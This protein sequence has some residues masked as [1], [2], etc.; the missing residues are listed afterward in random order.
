ML[1]QVR[2]RVTAHCL[3]RELEVST[4]TIYRDLD[5]LSAAGVPVYAERGPGGGCAL[6]EGYRTTLTGLTRDE[7]QAL[8]MLT[9][10]AP[11]VEL[12]VSQALRAALLKL[13]AAL[14]A[15]GRSEEERVRQRVHLDPVGWPAREEPVPFLGT[16]QQAVWE[17]RRLWVTYRLPF[18]A[19]VEW[20]V[21]PY[22]LVA[23][24]GAWHLVA[25]REGHLRV[26]RMSHIVAARLG[27]ET[28]ARPAGFDLAEAWRTWC[29][30]S[31]RN[32]PTFIVRARVARELLPFLAK[33][34]GEGPSAASQAAD[35]EGRV[36]MDLL[37]ENLEAAREQILGY[38]RAVEVVAPWVLR[39]SV[40]DHARQI[41]ALYNGTS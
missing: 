7:V 15:A 1:L 3:A 8:F 24:G 39:E 22:G 17:D 2:G 34:L 18:G 19:E 6:V 38:G 36:E 16:A 25:A 26:L 33:Q 20:V 37:F 21:D 14:P 9:I 5:A 35:D 23:K 12:G 31:E 41:V 10:P 30:E 13:A 29:A 27:D 11:L 40:L 32:R 28:F 4:R